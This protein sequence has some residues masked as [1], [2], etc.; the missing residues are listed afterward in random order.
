M[1]LIIL[2]LQKHSNF[3]QKRGLQ[4]AREAAHRP[5]KGRSKFPQSFDFAGI[6][7]SVR[8]NLLYCGGGMR[9]YKSKKEGKGRRGEGRKIRGGYINIAFLSGLSGLENHKLLIYKGL[10]YFDV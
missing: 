9:I 10:Y 3:M 2:K 1:V 4:S 7:R 8:M 6:G 5:Q